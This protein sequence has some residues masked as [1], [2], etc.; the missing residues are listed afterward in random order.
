MNWY[1]RFSVE[2]EAVTKDL[3]K[4]DLR[5]IR[6]APAVP[7]KEDLRELIEEKY[8]YP[9]KIIDRLVLKLDISKELF[10]RKCRL[11][12][13]KFSEQQMKIICSVIDMT[14]EEKRRYFG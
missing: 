2:W 10:N 13:R 6:L 11:P 8:D 1:E 5:H 3:S 12:D 14:D 7:M 9:D 4:Y